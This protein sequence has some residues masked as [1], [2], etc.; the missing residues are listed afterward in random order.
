MN[1]QQKKNLTHLLIA[2]F[3]I[4]LSISFFQVTYKNFIVEDIN[5]TTFQFGLVDA[6]KEI[7]G[8]IAV[9]LV[10]IAMRFHERN[11]FIFSVVLVALGT[12]LFAFA[13]HFSE[14][15]LYTFIFSTGT[16][17]LFMYREYLITDLTNK[18]NRSTYFGYVASLGAGASLLGMFLISLLS[19]YVEKSIL[20]F[21]GCPI[22]F[23]SILFIKK[24]KAP[25][26][27]KTK[28]TQRLFLRKAYIPYYV[29][30]CLSL[31]REMVFITFASLLLIVKFE[32]SLATMALLYSLH[33]IIAVVTRPYVGKAIKKIGISKALSI[34]YL[35]VTLIFIGYATIHQVWIVY[36][37]FV[38]D[39]VFMGFDD[40]GISTYVGNL[41]PREELSSTLAV[42]STLAHVIAVTIPFV[43]A[44][45][46]YVLGSTIPFFIG[47]II[48]VAAFFVSIK[49]LN[50]TPSKS[51]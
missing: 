17:L 41:V 36:I 40:I 19:P 27:K 49:M 25:S 42:G 5:V 47:C 28:A 31:A 12:A 24:M 26:E 34:N 43:G 13:T 21:I 8:L 18:E 14:L 37:L 6:V 35:I 1:I 29:L 51:T 2:T 30:V 3:I 4:S 11:V 20:I 7:P 44:L 48:T 32:T 22:L 23:I 16:H 9:F 46:W 33:G 39:D 45:I 10:F 38:L 50:I 15:M